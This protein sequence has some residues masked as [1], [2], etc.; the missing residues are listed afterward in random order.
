[1]GRNRH[2]ETSGIPRDQETGCGGA[3][4][5][6]KDLPVVEVLSGNPIECIDVKGKRI[7]VTLMTKLGVNA[8]GA[9]EVID[10]GDEECIEERYCLYRLTSDTAQVIASYLICHPRVLEVRYP[11]L[12]SDPSFSIAARTLQ[13]GFGPIVDY[14][15]DDGWHRLEA[16]GDDVHD[17]IMELER[18]LGATS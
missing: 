7:D 14:R 3:P 11:G 16:T 9:V 6:C 1:M 5:E 18:K 15:I 10:L 17:Q 12:K 4:F 8:K 13:G 2:R